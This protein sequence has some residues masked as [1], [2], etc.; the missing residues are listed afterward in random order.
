MKIVRGV[1]LLVAVS[2][3]G[4]G[5]ATSGSRLGRRLACGVAIGADAIT[6][7]GAGASFPAPLY[8][9]GSRNTTRHHPERAD[10]LSSRWAAARASSS[11]QQHRWTSAPATRR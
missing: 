10:Q 7:Q 5:L 3:M 11:S 1:L 4:V 6:L 2:L 8:R 9:S